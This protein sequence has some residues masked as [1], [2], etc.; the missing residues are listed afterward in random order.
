MYY[1]AE[2]IGKRIQYLRQ[3]RGLTQESLAD[4]LGVTAGHLN[5]IEK[6]TKGTSMDL[7]IDMTEYF[8]VSSDY[9]LFGKRKENKEIIESIHSVIGQLREIE[10]R[11]S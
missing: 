3:D 5:K 8:D 10:K 2:K 1:D 4:G 7:L 6:G 9:I 11:I